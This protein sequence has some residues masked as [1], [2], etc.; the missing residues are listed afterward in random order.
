MKLIHELERQAGA[1]FRA[2]LLQRYIR[3]ARRALGGDHVHAERGDEP[4]DFFAW[5][6]GYVDQLNPLHPAARNPDLLP[7]MTGWHAENDVQADLARLAGFEGQKTWT[8]LRMDRD[9][10][11]DADL[12][13][14]D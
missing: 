6:Q 7:R 4:V 9:G 10:D 13:D 14:D 12:E 5:A 2:R 3:A 1:W 11:Q 8:I